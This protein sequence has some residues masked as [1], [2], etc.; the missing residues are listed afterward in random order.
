MLGNESSKRLIEILETNESLKEI[1]V[2]S[3]F[4]I[5]SVQKID[6]TLRYNT[7][8]TK[9]DIGFFIFVF[10]HNSTEPNY[11]FIC[12]KDFFGTVRKHSTHV[13]L[14]RNKEFLKFSKCA[15]KTFVGHRLGQYFEDIAMYFEYEE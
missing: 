1:A 5:P 3:N 14:F 8:L 11:D 4:R 13:R 2:R 9:L 6:E 7:K 12:L 10:T 15:K